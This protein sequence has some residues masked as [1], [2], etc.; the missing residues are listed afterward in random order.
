MMA[1]SVATS[2]LARR[3]A[4]LTSSSLSSSSVVTKTVVIRGSSVHLLNGSTR[5]TGTVQRSFATTPRSAATPD[6]D[7]DQ[8]NILPVR[9]TLIIEFF[10]VFQNFE[11]R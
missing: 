5:T 11:K 2:T 10:F 1:S 7:K 4:W 6:P 9:P 3:A 8:D